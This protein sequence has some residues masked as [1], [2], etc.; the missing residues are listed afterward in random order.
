MGKKR[1]LLIATNDLGKSGVPEVIMS[2]VRLLHN[3]Y[4]FDI[5]ITRNN[6]YYKSEFESY[7]GF[8]YLIEE[9]KYKFKIARVFQKLIGSQIELKSFFKKKLKHQYDIIHS[10]KDLEGGSFLKLAKK[11]GTPIRINHCSRQYIKP[12][13]KV[14]RLYDKFLLKKI[15]KYS[16]KLVA[17]S[18]VAGLSLYGTKHEFYVL[19]NTYNEQYYYFKQTKKQENL[20]LTQIGTFL[21]LKNQCFSIKLLEQIMKQIPSARLQL[22]GKVYDKNYYDNLLNYLQRNNLTNNVD[23][24]DYDVDQKILL[25]KT[26]FSLIPSLYEGLSL[27]AIE[28]QAE[29]I[30]CFASKGVPQEVSCG[31]IDFLDL[32]VNVWSTRIIHEYNQTLGKRKKNN[33]SNFSNE[34]FCNKLLKLYK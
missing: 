3:D 12:K 22:I 25:D 11:Q 16:S 5:V 26:S 7:G 33:M 15:F 6:T 17:V 1:V 4:I 24:F 21:P 13:K 20:V 14:S 18:N 27:V 23:I 19:Y 9:K 31:G 10:F 30:K 32:D 29:G 34:S 8:V 28:S 2:I